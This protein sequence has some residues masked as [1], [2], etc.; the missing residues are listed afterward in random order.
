MISNGIVFG[1]ETLPVDII[2]LATG[3]V[4]NKAVGFP[5]H[6]RD[7]EQLDEHW[8]AIGGPSAYGTI[9][10]HG[11]PNLFLVKGPNT[12]TGHTSAILVAEK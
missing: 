10:L 9:A 2:V 5:I 3:Y 11:F 8:D 7:S 6:G 1:E 12:V 4:T